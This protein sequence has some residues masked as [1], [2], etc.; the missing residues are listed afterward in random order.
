M[1][2]KM[3]KSQEQSE[4]LQNKELEAIAGGRLNDL[5]KNL[6]LRGKVARWAAVAASVVG[7]SV[8]MAMPTEALHRTDDCDERGFFAIFQGSK[9]YATMCFANAGDAEV[10]IAD[11]HRVTSGNNAGYIITN[12][13]RFNFGKWK[14][15]DFIDNG[16]GTV[17]ILR[18]VIY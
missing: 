12:K 13:G 2:L 1:D 16:Y 10:V 9:H 17:T 5:V 6:S 7:M 3:L 8:G 18:I 15:F 11:V 4:Q 14:G